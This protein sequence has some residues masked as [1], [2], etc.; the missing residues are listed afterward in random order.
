MKLLLLKTIFIP[1]ENFIVTN[2]N[3]IYSVINICNTLN[4]YMITIRYEGYVIPS[5]YI[6]FIYLLNKI[7]YERHIN[8]KYVFHNKNVGKKY[9]LQNSSY[10]TNYDKYLYIDH[11]IIFI[12]NIQYFLTY[13]LNMIDCI[14]N[15][16]IIKL[17]SF[18]H[19]IDIRHN[20][21]NCKMH[22]INNV[23]VMYSDDN[24][25]ITSA[26]FITDKLTWSL[27]SN[28]NVDIIYGDEDIVIGNILN[29]N[30]YANVIICDYYVIHP[31]EKNKIY[32][33]WKWNQ[34]FLMSL[35]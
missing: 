7:K 12:L 22:V 34:I 10:E 25:N 27:F 16:K 20:F 6:I 24:V 33:N 13:C 23:N 14:L 26:C 28:I 4:K 5:C 3:S 15:D 18:N 21:I 29:I 8:I 30:N 9:I 1:D 2:I 11:D 32:T 17:L 19:L 31:Y 35:K